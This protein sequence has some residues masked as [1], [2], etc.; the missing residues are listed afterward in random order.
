[1]YI[2][3]HVDERG[4]KRERH[5]QGTP[6]MLALLAEMATRFIANG[7]GFTYAAGPLPSISADNGH[8]IYVERHTKH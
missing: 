7:V 4:Q 5:E 1:M 6:A 3:Y 8:R 2:V